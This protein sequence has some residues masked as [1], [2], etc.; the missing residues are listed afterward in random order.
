[1][2][3]SSRVGGTRVGGQEWP[4]FELKLLIST[5]DNILSPKVTVQVLDCQKA[6]SKGREEKKGG[7]DQREGEE[8]KPWGQLT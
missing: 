8:C 1:M 5:G 7:K 2:E 4:P 6:P 3:G